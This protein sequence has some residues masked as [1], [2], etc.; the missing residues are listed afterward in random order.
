MEI[1]LTPDQEAHI[2][3]LAAQ[4]GRSVDD[5]VVE[6]LAAWVEQ[7]TDLNAFRASLDDAEEGIARGQGRPI[8]RESLRDIAAD[9]KRRGRAHAAER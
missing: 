8:T 2:A 1:R 6:A 7:R 5:V 4:A 3:M 9:V